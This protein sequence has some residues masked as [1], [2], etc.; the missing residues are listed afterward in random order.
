MNQHLSEDRISHWLAGERAPQEERHVRECL[1]CQAAIA[2]TEATLAL[3]RGSLRHGSE[4]LRPPA[5]DWSGVRQGRSIIRRPLAWAVA[6]AALLLAA[7]PIYQAQ[8]ARYERETARA[9]AALLE[10]VDA[11]ISRAIAPPMESLAK[12]AAW[13]T[14]TT[15]GTNR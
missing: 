8:T 11:G 10:Q 15:Q 13:D 3:F 14:N 4:A 12:L 6:A 2:H 5:L 7:L 1:S 9:D